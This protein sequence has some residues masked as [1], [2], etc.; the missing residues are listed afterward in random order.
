[1]ETIPHALNLA[2]VEPRCPD[3]VQAS[4]AQL[5]SST[6]VAGA[7]DAFA[8]A[9]RFTRGYMQDLTNK[10]SGFTIPNQMMNSLSNT[11]THTNGAIVS[12]IVVTGI[13]L[14][15]HVRRKPTSPDYT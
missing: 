14:K 3:P 7:T 15:R 8:I 2:K 9:S 11:M 6:V 10:G 4:I 1:M 13:D 12:T 5:A